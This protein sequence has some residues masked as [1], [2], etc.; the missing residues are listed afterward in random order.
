MKAASSIL[1]IIYIRWR[2][3]VTISVARRRSTALPACW[4]SAQARRYRSKIRISG[5]I[6][7]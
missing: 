4:R 1:P 2:W 6:R 5:E 3:Q 7:K